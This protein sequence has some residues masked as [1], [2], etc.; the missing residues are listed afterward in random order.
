MSRSG[1]APLTLKAPRIAGRNESIIA[2]AAFVLLAWIVSGHLSAVNLSTASHGVAVGLIMLS[3]VLLAGYGGQVSLCQLTFVG[4]GA[5]AMSKVAGGGSILGVLAAMAF[6]AVIGAIVALPALR[7]RGLYLALLTLAFGQTMDTAFFQNT[8]A[9]G[10]SGA[11]RVGRVHLGFVPTQSERAYF[12]LL[13]IT[14]VLIGAGLLALRRSSFGR[15]LTAMSDS[16]AASVTLGMSLTTTKLAVFALSAIAL[17]G[18]GGAL[19]GGQQGQVDAS[20]FTVLASLVLLLL[21]VV[22]GIRTVSGVLVAGLVF[23]IFPVIQTHVLALRDLAYLGTG[24][25]AIGIGQ[26][27]NGVI[28]GDTPLA[29]LRARKA[30]GPGPPRPRHPRQPADRP[31]WH[32]S[33]RGRPGRIDA[34]RPGRIDAAMSAVPTLEVEGISVRFGGVQALRDVT[35]GARSARSPGWWGRTARARPPC[36]T[37]S[38][39]SCDRRRAPCG[40]PVSISPASGPPAGAASVWPAPSSGSRSSGP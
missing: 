37:S 24:L 12:M 19:Y 13:C 1:A 29:K 2:G 35:V 40:W 34:G 22:W 38:A 25:A 31:R 32:W 26:N 10:S 5:F 11:L 16:P 15:R 17:A 28:G 33:A 18:L 21:C 6:C 27:P 36:S 4:L 14:F 7:L 30:A 3:L 8:A 39:G 20:D 23:A 9:F